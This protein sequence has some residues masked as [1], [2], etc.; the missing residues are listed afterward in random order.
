MASCQFSH[1][2]PAFHSGSQLMAMVA[3]ARYDLIALLQGHLHADDNRFLADIEMAKAADRAHS[4]ELASLF[5]ETPDQQHVAQG[6]QFLFPGEFERGP[7]AVSLSSPL[8]LL[9][10]FRDA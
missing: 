1:R 3:V 10:F 7:G 5:L 4:V 9:C 8:F 2:A 6:R